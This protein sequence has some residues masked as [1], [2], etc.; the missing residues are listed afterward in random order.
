M[1]R[2]VFKLFF[3]SLFLFGCA[4]DKLYLFS[5]NEREDYED[6]KFNKAIFD[7]QCIPKK[8]TYG[9]CMI[10]QME[11]RLNKKYN[12]ND[13]LYRAETGYSYNECVFDNN[14][15]IDDLQKFYKSALDCELDYV[16]YKEQTYPYIT[17]N[18]N[19]LQYQ[20]LSLFYRYYND[21]VDHKIE[22]ALDLLESAKE[23]KCIQENFSSLSWDSPVSEIKYR[24]YEEVKN[25]D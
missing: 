5:S 2:I 18:C 17:K 4:N 6:Y 14:N 10:L 21:C 3:I 8:L 20:K 22:L 19:D 11:L 7:N 25:C 15:L 16:C 1:A 23:N 13:P 9:Q 12:C 24:S